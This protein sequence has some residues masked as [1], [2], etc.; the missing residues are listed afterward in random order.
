MVLFAEVNLQCF[1]FFFFFMI[2]STNPFT[3]TKKNILFIGFMHNCIIKAATI[4]SPHSTIRIG[5]LASRYDTYRNTLFRLE[6]I[7]N[8]MSI[9][10][11]WSILHSLFEIVLSHRLKILFVKVS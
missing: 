4:H 3:A 5:I 7:S 8:Y 2:Q 1:F 10:L 11:W 6:I 9:I